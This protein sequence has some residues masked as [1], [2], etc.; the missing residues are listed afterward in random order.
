MR[1]FASLMDFSQSSL[2]IDLTDPR[3]HFRFP[4]CWLFPRWGHQPHAQPPTWRTRSPYLYPLETGWPNYTPRHRVPIL[5]AFND[6]HGLQW[7]YSFPRSPH[8]EFGKKLANTICTTLETRNCT[9]HGTRVNLNANLLLEV[10][11]PFIPLRHDKHVR[12][13][14]NTALPFSLKILLSVLNFS[15]FC[16]SKGDYIYCP[17][18]F[19]HHQL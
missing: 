8:G 2:T 13:K 4:N 17:S 5:V 1:T 15:A 18:Y 12:H 11:F 9:I 14:W 3:S 10:L 19:H 6:M 16:H 7:D